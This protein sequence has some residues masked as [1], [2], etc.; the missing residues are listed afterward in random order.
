MADNFDNGLQ[1]GI[2]KVLL[3]AA[4]LSKNEFKKQVTRRELAKI[5]LQSIW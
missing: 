5:D 1:A 2:K 3:D 4:T